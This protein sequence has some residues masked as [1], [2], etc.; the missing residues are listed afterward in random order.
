MK[1]SYG[2]QQ[3]FLEPLHLD[4]HENGRGG[5]VEATGARQRATCG[6]TVYYINAKF[7]TPPPENC[8]DSQISLDI[9]HHHQHQQL[10]QI[11]TLPLST[12][13][14]SSEP[15]PPTSTISSR[16]ANSQT[17]SMVKYWLTMGVQPPN[18]SPLQNFTINLTC[19]TAY[20]LQFFN[21]IWAIFLAFQPS[22]S[23]AKF[24]KNIAMF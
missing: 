19:E 1:T 6:N 7:Q 4:I 8:N 14:K 20:S 3:E 18:L 11:N 22:C 10:F 9:Y 23:I 16:Y 2:A 13:T 12:Y 5:R 24:C 17:G 15:P 21:R